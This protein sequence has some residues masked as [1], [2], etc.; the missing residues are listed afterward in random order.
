MVEGAG[1][2]PACEKKE[3]LAKALDLS[4]ILPVGAHP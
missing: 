4:A 2:E 3:E 1:F